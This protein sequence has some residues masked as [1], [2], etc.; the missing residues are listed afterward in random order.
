MNPIIES[1][2]RVSRLVKKSYEEART[3]DEKLQ[4]A[5]VARE[6]TEEYRNIV[7][8]ERLGNASNPH[9]NPER[10]T[11]SIRRSEKRVPRQ[12]PSL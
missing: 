8:H 12:M 1:L 3:H 9:Q 4:L 11:D 2:E 6:I 5:I 10:Q 7:E